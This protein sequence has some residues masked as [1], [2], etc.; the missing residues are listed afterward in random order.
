MVGLFILSIGLVYLISTVGSGNEAMTV[1]GSPDL[2]SLLEEGFSRRLLEWEGWTGLTVLLSLTLICFL[3]TLKRK[4]DSDRALTGYGFVF[5]MILFGLLA[6][7]GPEFFYLKDS[8]GHRMNTV[9]KFYMQGWLLL[10]IAAAY[11]SS[12]LIL[13]SKKRALIIYIPVIVLSVGVGLVY[14][15]MAI[16]DKVEYF[17]SNED[18]QLSLDGADNSFYL[19][20][21]EHLAVDWLWDAPFGTLVEAVGGS[22]ST[23]ARISTHS[24]QPALVGWPSHEYQWRGSYDEVGNR[25]HDIRTLYTSRNA[26]EIMNILKMYN[27]RYVFVGN[28]EYRSYDIQTAIFDS[29]MTLV[30]NEGAVYIYESPYWSD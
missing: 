15:Y 3:P 7:I 19:T 16:E 18:N 1:Y 4:Q 14:P 13:L 22:Y 28:L 2:N 21:Y 17:L 23:Y 25:E 20:G 29:T 8:F 27:I 9:F 10:S 5:L 26:N 11:G 24:G 12:I 30:F 6:I